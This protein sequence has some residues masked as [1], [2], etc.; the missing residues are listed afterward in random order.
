MLWLDTDL[1]VLFYLDLHIQLVP[2]LM[3]MRQEPLHGIL[4]SRHHQHMDA[5]SWHLQI[6]LKTCEVCVEICVVRICFAQSL[7]CNNFYF[8]FERVEKDQKSSV[9]YV[10]SIQ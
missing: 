3:H 5:L 7:H 2:A 10:C 9:V 4:L 8:L 1:L 6:L